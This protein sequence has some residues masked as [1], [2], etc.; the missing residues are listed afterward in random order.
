MWLEGQ[1]WITVSRSRAVGF[2]MLVRMLEMVEQSSSVTVGQ[3]QA[4][5]GVAAVLG[6]SG[7]QTRPSNH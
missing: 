7:P 5:V 3:A 6:G 2:I 1:I 4:G